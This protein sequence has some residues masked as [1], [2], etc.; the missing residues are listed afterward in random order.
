MNTLSANSDWH[1]E[2]TKTVNGVQQGK[3]EQKDCAIRSFFALRIIYFYA[4]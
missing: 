3:N 1:D 4:D 2:I